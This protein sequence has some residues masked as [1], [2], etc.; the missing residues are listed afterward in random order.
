[1]HNVSESKNLI[2][3]TKIN[4]NNIDDF[5][6]LVYSPP[7]QSFSKAGN[8]KGVEDIRGTLFFNALNVI[9]EKKPKYCIMENVDNLQLTSESPLVYG[10]G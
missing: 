2:D 5:D 7:C 6:L 10:C 3:V 4:I 9:K 1:M 8:R